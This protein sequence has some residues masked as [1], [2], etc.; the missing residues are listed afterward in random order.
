MQKVV[1]FVI[2]LLLLISC[3]SSQVFDQYKSI[4]NNEWESVNRIN[5]KVNVIDTI[6]KHHIFVNLRNNNNYEFSN[7]FLRTK[8][9][10]PNNF[11]VIDTLEY[12][13][14]DANGKWLGEGFSDLK[15]NKLT[16]KENVLFSEKGTYIFSINQVMR[17]RND[18][19]GTQPLKGV[20]DVGLR[21]EKVKID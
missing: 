4:E 19:N 7:L 10:F 6:N 11:N 16:L 2:S 3:D 12:E 13:M 9:Q 18:V 21:I 20:T 1:F 5:F 17:K 15:E 8:I 14:T